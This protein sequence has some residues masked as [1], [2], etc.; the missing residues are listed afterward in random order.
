MAKVGLLWPLGIP[1]L[2]LF[3][4]CAFGGLY[5]AEQGDDGAQA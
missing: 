1:I 2:V 3:I 4:M 5:S